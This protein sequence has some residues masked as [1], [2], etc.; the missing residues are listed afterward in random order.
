MEVKQYVEGYFKGVR[1]S[2]FKFMLID[3]S[4][5]NAGVMEGKIIL[6]NLPKYAQMASGTNTDSGITDG[7]PLLSCLPL[8]KGF[9]PTGGLSTSQNFEDNRDPNQ[10]QQ[11]KNRTLDSPIVLRE[12]SGPPE[13][14]N[15]LEVLPQGNFYYSNTLFKKNNFF[16]C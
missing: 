8:P 1:E 14:K 10:V 7:V 6:K 2:E 9:I 4:G 12:Q 16:C 13:P 11:F 3:G 15:P 5:N